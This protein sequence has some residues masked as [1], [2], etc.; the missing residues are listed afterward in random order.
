MMNPSEA[1][2]P[3]PSTGLQERIRAMKASPEEAAMLDGGPEV[4]PDDGEPQP[5]DY[6]VP[7]VETDPSVEKLPEWVKVPPDLGFPPGKQVSFLRFRSDWCDM[8]KDG[9]QQVIFWN[10]R[11]SEETRG[12]ARA[13]GDANRLFVELAKETIRSING[14]KA[15]WSGRPGPGNVQAW[16]E[17]VGSKVRRIVQT[18]YMKTHQLSGEEIADFF[19]NCVAVRSAG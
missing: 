10:L 11:A 15:D 5:G 8:P 13:R 2:G 3:G 16:W 1:Q 12:V 14:H 6:G 4:E 9:D 17:N 19:S 18:Y 7:Q